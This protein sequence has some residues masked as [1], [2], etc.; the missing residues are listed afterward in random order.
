MSVR[1]DVCTDQLNSLREVLTREV[2]LEGSLRKALQ[3][4]RSVNSSTLDRVV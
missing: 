2:M 3:H 4:Y 1:P